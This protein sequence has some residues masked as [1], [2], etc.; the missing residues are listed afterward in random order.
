MNNLI[1]GIDQDNTIS[2]F[3]DQFIIYATK[4][5]YNIDI[6]RAKRERCLEESII[7][8]SKEDQSKI[9]N[10]IMEIDDFWLT[11]EFI[12]YAKNYVEYLATHYQSYIVTS[13]W[14]NED[15]F[16]NTKLEWINNNI[17]FMNNRVLFS[18]EKW[19]LDIDIIIDD[20]PNTL[21][22]CNEVG[23]IT[24][25][26]DWPYNKNIDTDWR[27]SK[28]YNIPVYMQQIESFINN[29]KLQGEV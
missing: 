2:D 15:K 19:K 24:I 20:K 12:P 21:V 26:Y 11:M 29:E 16:Y 28:W 17:P 9:M 4:L 3:T 13:P 22:K 25:A 23:I 27:M 10:D 5:G 14:R 8:Y 1:I 6:N 18:H 7:G